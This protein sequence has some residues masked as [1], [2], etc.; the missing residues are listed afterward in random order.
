[1]D[2]PRVREILPGVTRRLITYGI[3]QPAD[4]QARDVAFNG[5]ATIFSVLYRGKPLGKVILNV[6]GRFNVYNSPGSS[7]RPGDRYGLRNHLHRMRLYRG[8]HRR[9]ELKGQAGG[10]S[11]VDDYGPP[12]TEIRETLAAARQVWQGRR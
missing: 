2:D 7:A 11:V 5:P 10:V 8:V 3:D 12:P 6:P 1:L 4:Y 9:L